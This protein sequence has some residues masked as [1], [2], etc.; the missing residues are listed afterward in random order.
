MEEKERDLEVRVRLEI[1]YSLVNLGI[2]S[3]ILVNGGAIIALLA[4]LGNILPKGISS[5]EGMEWVFYN[6][7]GGLTFAL[8]S[9]VGAY[10]YQVAELRLFANRTLLPLNFSGAVS[11]WLIV[12]AARW[13]AV[14]SL[15]CFCMGSYKAVGV[16][17]SLKP[18]KG[19]LC[20]CHHKSTH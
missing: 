6:Y 16:F 7:F 20:P 3:L 4:F 1:I 9:L 15:I 18:V 12:N 5:S 14:L 2:K 19:A 17:Q 13:S 10:S 11:T 8:L